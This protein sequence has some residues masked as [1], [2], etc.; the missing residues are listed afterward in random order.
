MQ[1]EGEKLNND[2]KFCSDT[3]PIQKTT[4]VRRDQKSVTPKSRKDNLQKTL[5]S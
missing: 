3:Y 2:L 4:L 1:L 5:H